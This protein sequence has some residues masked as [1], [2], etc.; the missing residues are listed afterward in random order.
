MPI[1]E[2]GGN[3]RADG[4]ARGWRNGLERD[5]WGRHSLGYPDGFGR[6]LLF[7]FGLVGDD[8]SAMGAEFPRL[9]CLIAAVR[10]GPAGTSH[11]AHPLSCRE[12]TQY[13]LLIRL[14]GVYSFQVNA[15]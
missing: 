6:G 5:G 13:K 2:P 14:V 9:A 3:P 12:A 10:A 8:R 15:K 4:C 11:C 1:P 7:E